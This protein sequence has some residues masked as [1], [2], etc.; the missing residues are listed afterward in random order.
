MQVLLLLILLWMYTGR[1][2]LCSI[3]VAQTLKR[4]G[5]RQTGVRRVVQR[6]LLLLLSSTTQLLQHHLVQTMQLQVSPCHDQPI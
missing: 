6:R 5:N 3:A 4:C 2:K 1:C